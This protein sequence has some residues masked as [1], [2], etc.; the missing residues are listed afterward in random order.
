MQDNVDAH[1]F[2]VPLDELPDAGDH[3]LVFRH[4][5]PAGA[6]ARRA[7]LVGLRDCPPPIYLRVGPEFRLDGFPHPDVPF[8]RD[9]EEAQAESF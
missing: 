6:P 2:R 8:Q 5:P 4:V 3:Q 1:A 9:F 7:G